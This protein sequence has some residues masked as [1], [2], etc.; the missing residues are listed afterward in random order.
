[1]ELPVLSFR[2]GKV[3]EATIR[4][5]F[6]CSVCHDPHSSSSEFFLVLSFGHCK[7]R[8]TEDTAMVILQA[9][10]GGQAA[11]FRTRCL[12]D[13]V[14]CFSVSSPAVGFH[15][16]NLRSFECSQFKIFFNLWNRG[17]PNFRLE[18][19]RWQSEEDARWT[20]V[21]RH[22]PLLTGPNKI[23]VKHVR[24]FS[25]QN[26]KIVSNFVRQSVFNRLQFGTQSTARQIFLVNALKP[27]ILGRQ[28][29]PSGPAHEPRLAHSLHHPRQSD[30]HPIN[31]ESTRASRKCTASKP[32]AKGPH[33]LTD[34]P[35]GRP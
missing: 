19:R 8:L 13:H 7:F 2:P 24:P 20:R 9:V 17:G 5:K 15:I 6:G 32:S 1:M 31:P 22:P 23:P 25:S 16:Y 35:S 33:S 12:N 4:Q 10:L 34:G 27:S 11:A 26:S 18:L 29:L 3:V 14:F 30:S 21:S 28:R